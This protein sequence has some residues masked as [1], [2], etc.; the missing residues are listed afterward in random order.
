MLHQTCKQL[1]ELTW[2]W[3]R[4][5]NGTALVAAGRHAA[6][7]R[8]SRCWSLM[9]FIC[10]VWHRLVLL[11][12]DVI[13]FLHYLFL[14]VST[15]DL[16]ICCWPVKQKLRTAVIVVVLAAIAAVLY[17]VDVVQRPFVYLSCCHYC[18][19]V[20]SRDL[21]RSKTVDVL[22]GRQWSWSCA[23][24]YC[25]KN[26]LHLVSH[27]TTSEDCWAINSTCKC[28]RSCWLARN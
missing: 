19:R 20:Y 13:S 25:L 6:M 4:Q 8:Q 24:G 10:W 23:W 21:S 5:R 9:R 2:L 22:L 14:I 15:G 18:N 3:R 12:F 28:S 17:S 7:W 26:Q 11:H 1:V 16:N 27:R